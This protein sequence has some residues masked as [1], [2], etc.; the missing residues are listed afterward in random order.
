MTRPNGFGA[1]CNA[2]CPIINHIRSLA[3][4]V[5]VDNGAGLKAVW[6]ASLKSG[7]SLRAGNQAQPLVHDGKL[8]IMTG[9]NDAFAVS[10]EANAVLWEYCSNVDP[11]LVVL[12]QQTGN[13][14]WPMS[15]RRSAWQKPG[16]KEACRG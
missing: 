13:L 5:V 7:I 10:V 11:K 15:R 9:K 16:K 2:F 6:R 3:T 12:D 1:V 4:P 14:V 8:Y